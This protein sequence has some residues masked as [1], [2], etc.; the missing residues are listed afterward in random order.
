MNQVWLSAS[1]FPSG[2]HAMAVTGSGVRIVVVVTGPDVDE[3]SPPGVTAG[4][5]IVE[6]LG[7]PGE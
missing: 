3:E 2:A 1:R 5:A 6:P 7:G 4:A